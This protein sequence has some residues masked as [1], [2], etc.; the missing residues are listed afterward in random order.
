[1][2]FEAILFIAILVIASKLGG[3]LLHRIGQPTILGN[4]LA[5]IIVD[6]LRAIT[7]HKLERHDYE[8]VSYLIIMRTKK[9][10]RTLKIE[11]LESLSSP[12]DEYFGLSL[13][14]LVTDH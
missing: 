8:I 14:T 7:L 10:F 6:G 4:V 5:G 9:E 3:E 1:M 2:S 12:N 13:E 11:L